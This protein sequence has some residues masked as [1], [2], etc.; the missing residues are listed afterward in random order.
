MK[1]IILIITIITVLLSVNIVM[2]KSNKGTDRIIDLLVNGAGKSGKTPVGI[3]NAPGHAELN[4]PPEFILEWGSDGTGN[5]EFYS[6]P[7]S[8]DTDSQGN[9]YVLDGKRIQKF[10]NQGVFITKSQW[11]TGGGGMAIDSQDYV[12]VVNHE[13]ANTVKKFDSNL[14]FIATIYY[15]LIIVSPWFGV[16]D[17][18]IDSSDN[19]FIADRWKVIKMDTN[20][21]II[22]E[23]GSRCGGGGGQSTEIIGSDSQ[24]NICYAGEFAAAHAIGIDLSGNVYVI[25][26]WL[27]HV[28]VFDNDGNYIKKWG[29]SGS[30]DGYFRNPFG[31]AF[32]SNNLIYIAD[33]WNNRVQKLTNDGTFIL[34]W[35]SSYLNPGSGP[36][37]LNAPR[38]VAMG[39]D[40]SI[41]VADHSNYRI[42]K[43]GY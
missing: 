42:Q 29:T 12:Y 8:I 7:Y 19:L 10:T 37:E 36:G 21:N 35:G 39:L 34:K 33:F 4:S 31:G 16:N 14:N 2:A 25:E 32:D 11:G 26:G 3:L 6:G 20:G 1:K 13:I 24:G 41:Y 9:V 23:W 38:D 17:V 28:Q 18:A 5:G 43:F 22:K 30:G 40:G 15:E 27:H